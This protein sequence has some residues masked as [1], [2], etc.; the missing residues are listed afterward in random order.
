MPVEQVVALKDRV[1]VHLAVEIHPVCKPVGRKPAVGLDVGCREQVVGIERILVHY[2]HLCP[3]GAV[4]LQIQRAPEHDQIPCR[5][6]ARE[7]IEAY[8]AAVLEHGHLLPLRLGSAVAAAAGELGV[9]VK[10][11][12][13][14]AGRGGPRYGEPAVG[15]GQAAAYALVGAER[16][17]LVDGHS[18]PRQRQSAR[19]E[20]AGELDLVA[21]VG[22]TGKGVK[23]DRR[24][25][26]R[27]GKYLDLLAPRRRVAVRPVAVVLGVYLQHLL[28][29]PL[30]GAPRHGEPAVGARPGVRNDI[31]GQERIVLLYLHNG[32]WHGQ[33][34]RHE[35]SRKG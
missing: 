11:G 28:D 5:R 10:V 26:D 24:G 35:A 27:R 13:E 7:G 30:L 33:A 21:G 6:A 1:H 20:P 4:Q 32:P 8:V 31:V 16:I 17:V 22:R 2:V 23:G 9:Q 29:E 15:A 19:R 25:R 3:L 34:V 14:E 12:L 18:R